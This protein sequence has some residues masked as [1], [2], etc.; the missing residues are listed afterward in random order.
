[1]R[2]RW[3]L[4]RCKDFWTQGPD[5]IGDEAKKIRALRALLTGPPP[6]HR[7]IHRWEILLSI[8]MRLFRL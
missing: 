3:Q 4:T 1:M 8:I 6:R 7:F 5:Y 2:L